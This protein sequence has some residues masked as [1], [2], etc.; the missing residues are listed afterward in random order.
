M[1]KREELKLLQ[2]KWLTEERKKGGHEGIVLLT[3]LS[4]SLSF[5]LSVLEDRYQQYR[6]NNEV[7]MVCKISQRLKKQ[8]PCFILEVFWLLYI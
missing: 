8:P 1:G 3:S 4:F 2:G 6:K 5:C 7:L